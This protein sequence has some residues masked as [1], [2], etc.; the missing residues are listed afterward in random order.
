[1]V[2]GVFQNNQPFPPGEGQKPLT[3][4]NKLVNELNTNFRDLVE[5]HPTIENTHMH[6]LDV[7]AFRCDSLGTPGD[8]LTFERYDA[9]SYPGPG[10]HLFWDNLHLNIKKAA[11]R[12]KLATLIRHAIDRW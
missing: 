8:R 9:C 6:F 12:F 5:A 1:M 3:L 2:V 7:A 4:Q 10:I 11:P